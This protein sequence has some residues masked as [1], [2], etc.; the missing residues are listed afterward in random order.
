MLGR[1][2]RARGRGRALPRRPPSRARGLRSLLAPARSAG[3]ASRGFRFRFP[4]A[5]Q[6]NK[7]VPAGVS[8]ASGEGRGGG[9]RTGEMAASPGT[10]CS[11][12]RLDS[13][14]R[15]WTPSSWGLARSPVMGTVPSSSHISPSL[16][17][18]FVPEDSSTLTICPMLRANQRPWPPVSLVS[19]FWSAL[20]NGE[21]WQEIQEQKKMRSKF[22]PLG[23]GPSMRSVSAGNSMQGSNSGHQACIASVLPAHQPCAG[24]AAHHGFSVCVFSSRVLMMRMPQEG[25]TRGVPLTNY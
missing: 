22:I 20:A 2:R 16:K 19:G 14:G 3:P 5:V 10:P 8:C 17:L 6:G 7:V 24:I 25:E 1:W 21:H 11:V 15:K 18:P 4:A 23:S 9:G 13:R 12:L